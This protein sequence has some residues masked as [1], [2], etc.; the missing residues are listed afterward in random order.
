MHIF[1][2]TGLFHDRRIYKVNSFHAM[3]LEFEI[4]AVSFSIL[5]PV[6]D[7][8]KELRNIL[9]LSSRHKKR[10]KNYYS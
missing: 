5:H 10:R 6:I 8:R 1:F 9:A 3:A 7:K 4:G 2:Y